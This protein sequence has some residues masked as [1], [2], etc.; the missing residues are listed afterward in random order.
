MRR[1][2][3]NCSATHFALAQPRALFPGSERTVDS[4]TTS[5]ETYYRG[6]RDLLQRQKRSTEDYYR[7]KR[8]L[9]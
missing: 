4:T 6:K 1:R 9:L 8:D 7:G 3:P 2:I 5:K